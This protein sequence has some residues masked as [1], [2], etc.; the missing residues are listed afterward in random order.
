MA[1]NIILG[2]NGSGKTTFLKYVYDKAKLDGKKVV[3]YID[4]YSC[5]TAVSK[6]KINKLLYSDYAPYFGVDEEDLY[7]IKC[8]DYR[9]IMRLILSE[10]DVLIL[11]DLEGILNIEQLGDVFGVL[12][13]IKDLWDEIFISGHCYDGFEYFEDNAKIIL[14]EEYGK[15]R[16][17]TSAEM[18]S[19]M[20]DEY[21]VDS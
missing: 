2:K 14:C 16:E 10:G 12:Y 21:T 9:E 11:D 20:Q 13:T 15:T 1:I 4:D 6:A 8:E 18:W 17:I 7:N 5:N 3:S 19:V